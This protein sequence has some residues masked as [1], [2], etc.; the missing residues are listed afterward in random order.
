MQDTHVPFRCLAGLSPMALPNGAHDGV[1]PNSSAPATGVAARPTNLSI[2][3][4]APMNGH[5]G[6]DVTPA[7]PPHVDGKANSDDSSCRP[8]TAA[9]AAAVD[10]H[11][12][13][14]DNHNIPPAIPNAVWAAPLLKRESTFSERDASDTSDDVHVGCRCCGQDC[15]GH[16][17]RQIE[18]ACRSMIA[19]GLGAVLEGV[20]TTASAFAVN[21]FLPLFAVRSSTTT[22]RQTNT[23]RDICCILADCRCLEL[24]R[25]WGRP[26][27]T[28]G[29][30][31]GASFGRV[32][33]P[34]SL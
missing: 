10:G 4:I 7:P 5:P 30:S 3:A 2:I 11:M 25:L 29:A 26:S 33:A 13:G 19:T 8:P 22:S 15:T 28:R 17:S 14:V 9:A 32:S 12:N 6:N 20:S 18:W 31:C 23:S 21:G 24:V 27:I 34:G 1:R 16:F